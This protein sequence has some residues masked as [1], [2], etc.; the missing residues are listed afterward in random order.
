[1]C[2]ERPSSRFVVARAVRHRRAGL[3]HGS[4]PAR[5]ALPRTP[6]CASGWGGVCATGWPCLPH[7][8]ACPPAGCRGPSGLGLSGRRVSLCRRARPFAA[9][10]WRAP[11]LSVPLPRVPAAAAAR[12]GKFQSG[13][14]SPTCPGLRAAG[15][16]S[17]GRWAPALEVGARSG[18]T[19]GPWPVPPS[20]A[21]HPGLGS[22][23]AGSLPWP[24]VTVPFCH[25]RCRLCALW[26]RGGGAA[27]GRL[28]VPYVATCS[29]RPR[30][31]VRPGFCGRWGRRPGSVISGSELDSIAVPAC[32]SCAAGVRLPGGT[33]NRVP[34]DVVSPRIRGHA[35]PPH[36][37]VRGRLGGG[38]C[39][40]S[41]AHG[42]PGEAPQAVGLHPAPPVFAIRGM[43][44]SLPGVGQDSRRVAASPPG[45]RRHR[46]RVPLSPAP[47]LVWG[48]GLRRW[49]V[50]RAV[51]PVAKGGA[52][53]PGQPDIGLRVRDA[54]HRP[55][56]QESRPPWLKSSQKWK[57]EKRRQRRRH[58]RGLSSRPR[59]ST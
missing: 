26:C 44:L 9:R 1:M 23:G 11:W 37:L 27:A 25:P 12:Y 34:A 32:V 28:G 56:L 19:P 36:V 24:S 33:P 8:A 45:R 21:R 2:P 4:Q 52:Q 22:L 46:P 13:C 35:S 16:G 50:P 20:S 15:G 59:G 57:Y 18:S 48:L 49:W 14:P 29:T 30:P 7:A 54:E 42:L 5:S 3:C 39:P 17:K 10:R 38:V 43:G 40:G 41:G 51:A 58:Q 53:A 6:G 47:L 31:S 55:P